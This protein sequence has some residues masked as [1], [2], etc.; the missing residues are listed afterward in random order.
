MALK[1]ADTTIVQFK[2]IKKKKNISIKL[3][4]KGCSCEENTVPLNTY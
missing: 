3:S 4:L 1:G 2:A